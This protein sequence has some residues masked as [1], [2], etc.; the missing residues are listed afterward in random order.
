MD[1][2]F[3][4]LLPIKTINCIL[5]IDFA[6]V[7]WVKA[8]RKYSFVCIK[9][10]QDVIRS[11]VPFSAMEK[12][13]PTSYFFKCHRSCIINLMHLKKLD[14]YNRKIHL[15][16]DQCVIISEILIKDFLQRTNADM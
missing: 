14:K 2:N 10:Q 4:G 5:F 15:A 8:A 16:D 1:R 6:E 13:L 9:G 11:I 7:V 3:T 12:M